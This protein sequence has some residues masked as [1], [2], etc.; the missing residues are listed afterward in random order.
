MRFAGSPVSAEEAHIVYAGVP[1]EASP[2]PRPGSRLAPARLREASL[3]VSLYSLYTRLDLSRVDAFGDAGD[4]WPAAPLEAVEAA[5]ALLK[6]G[7]ERGRGVVLAGGEHTVTLAYALASRGVSR[8]L[9]V[10]LDAH[11]DLL[12]EYKGYRL[13]GATVL[14]RMFEQG[15][16]PGEAIV[17]GVR[18]VSEATLEKA[19]KLGLEFYMLGDHRR[20][21]EE[22]VRRAGEAEWLHISVDMDVFD[23]G[24]A[25]GAVYPEPPGLTPGDVL[26]AV[27][28][29]AYASGG[30]VTMDVAE[31]TPLYDCGGATAALA[32]KLIVEYAGGLLCRRLSSCRIRH[33]A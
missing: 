6:R 24:F 22:A 23:P 18:G 4:V 2:A 31:Y 7:Y 26:E 30:V 15:L 19:E 20:G 5:A 14:S 3:H 9:L 8:K 13:A 27:A 28:R 29:L 1:L 25:P 12:D 16:G 33:R 11:L 21:V 32:V 17:V 10:V